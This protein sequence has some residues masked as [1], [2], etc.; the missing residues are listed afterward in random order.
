MMNGAV[1]AC[2]VVAVVLSFVCVVVVVVVATGSCVAQP[3]IAQTI[4]RMTTR[5]MG[6]IFIA[7]VLATD[8]PVSPAPPFVPRDFISSCRCRLLVGRKMFRNWDGPVPL[9]K[10]RLTVANAE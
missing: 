4:A 1:A 5:M 7:V 8:M 3:A 10:P 2:G 6:L 9:S